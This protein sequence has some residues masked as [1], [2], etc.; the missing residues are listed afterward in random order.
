MPVQVSVHGDPSYHVQPGAAALPTTIFCHAIRWDIAPAAGTHGILVQRLQRDAKIKF[1]DLPV[2]LSS[3]ADMTTGLTYRVEYI[4]YWECWAVIDGQCFPFKE[5]VQKYLLGGGDQLNDVL[6][7]GLMCGDDTPEDQAYRNGVQPNVR[8][9]RGNNGCIHDVYTVKVPDVGRLQGLW[10]GTW[11]I[12]GTV[13]FLPFAH[14]WLKTFALVGAGGGAAGAGMLFSVPAASLHHSPNAAVALTRESKGKFSR[15]DPPH[16][17]A[18]ITSET[19]RLF[20]RWRFQHGHPAPQA[21]KTI[22]GEQ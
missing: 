4:D 8:E 14:D 2:D 11:K 15:V 16:Q 22:W 17:T 10:T 9:K 6:M 3:V 13:Y 19:R 21:L 18:K 7:R 20:G 1:S 12:R 5:G